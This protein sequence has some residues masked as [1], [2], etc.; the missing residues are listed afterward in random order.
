MTTLYIYNETTGDINSVLNYSAD[1]F[2][3]ELQPGEATYVLTNE[4]EATQDIDDYKIEN[5]QVVK[6][7]LQ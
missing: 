2:E 4:A 5:G 6:R 1:D 3:V 7:L